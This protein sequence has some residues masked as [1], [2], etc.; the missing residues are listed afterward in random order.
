MSRT[1]TFS[2]S[3]T[4]VS[5]ESRKRAGARPYRRGENRSRGGVEVLTPLLVFGELDENAARGFR[6][7]KSDA[8]ARRTVPR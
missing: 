3:K 6:M 4:R 2:S 1:L 7:Q 5:D 8:L